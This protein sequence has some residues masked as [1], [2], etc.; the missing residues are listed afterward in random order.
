MTDIKRIAAR[1]IAGLCWLVMVCGGA[2]AQPSVWTHRYDNA[3]S[4][5]NAGE[6][7]LNTSNVNPGQFGKLFSYGV[8][9]DI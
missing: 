3:R 5:V 1:G 6:V 7:Q 2:W 4:G 9:A 8:D